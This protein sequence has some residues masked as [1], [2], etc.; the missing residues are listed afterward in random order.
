V[1][2]EVGRR[3][4]RLWLEAEVARGERIGRAPELRRVGRRR[5]I[6]EL[7]A[8]V[9]DALPPVALGTKMP[10]DDAVDQQ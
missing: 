10:R 8:E 7:L 2:R 5:P 4:R 1:R 3:R 6:G 9:V